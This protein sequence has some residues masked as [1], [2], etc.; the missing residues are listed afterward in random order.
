MDD[1]QFSQLLDR[2][3]LSWEGYRKVRKGVKKRVA[4]HMQ[5]LG[6]QNL[7]E[8]FYIL[9]NNP[10][11][12]RDGE[13]LI[14]VSISR[15]FR[16]RRLWLM[17]EEEIVPD[18]I[19]RKSKKINVW[20]AG[21]AQGQEV[22]SFKILWNRIKSKFDRLP[23]LQLWATD[24]NPDYLNKAMKGVYRESN[25][26]GIPEEIKSVCFRASKDK[27]LYFIA[28]HFKKNIKWETYDLVTQ[29]PPEE[30]FQIIFLRN[31]LLTYYRQE[32]KEPAFIKVLGSLDK[33]GFLI[34]GTHEK[35]PVRNRT[36]SE[37][38]GYSYIFQLSD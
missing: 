28:N 31:N 17:L 11:A 1:H 34:I 12:L 25:L 36:L 5:R 23:R 8:Y 13:L 4:R 14:T 35:L 24:V 3:N 21:C 29:P 20:S 33:G 9:N 26:K 2:F 32:I 10:E 37:F 16:D 38:K 27:S 7:E 30:K 6:C 19:K 15:F 22:Y 18:V